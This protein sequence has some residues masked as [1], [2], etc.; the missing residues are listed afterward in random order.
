MEPNDNRYWMAESFSTEIGT[1]L[2][3]A[4]QTFRGQA[5]DVVR[6]KEG[7]VRFG[8]CGGRAKLLPLG[9]SRS[10]CWGNTPW[11]TTAKATYVSP[12]ARGGE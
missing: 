6:R 12:L 11:G 9:E 1:C 5:R 8:H 7:V 3:A 4:G 10:D 2:P